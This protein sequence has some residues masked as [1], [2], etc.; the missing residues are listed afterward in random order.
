MKINSVCGVCVAS[1]AFFATTQAA[2][3]GMDLS[4]SA[5]A[6][7]EGASAE[8]EG[9]LDEPPPPPPAPEPEPEPEPEPVAAPPPPAP[10]PPAEDESS[11]K[12]DHSQV[13]LGV[14][15][16]GYREMLIGAAGGGGTATDTVVAP[17]VGVRMWLNPT[18][19]L[20]LGLG[21][22]ATAA[23]QQDQAGNDFDFPGPAAGIVHAG[24]PIALSEHKH[25]IFQLVPEANV[26]F[27]SN[28]VQGVGGAGDQVFRGLHFD[29]GARAG[30]EVQFGFIDIPQL[31]LQAGV[32]A[33]LTYDAT[34][35]EDDG[36]TGETAQMAFGTGVGDNPWN[37]FT[38]NVAAI[39]YLD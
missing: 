21:I 9:A 8:T 11:G 20:D 36:G 27:A 29:L 28:T 37:I 14:G 17:V 33:A 30:A 22:S 25:F 19:G 16:L 38:A 6:D 7:T 5:S 4:G 26:G 2:A 1:L 34:S 35:Y 10:A 24:V 39:Y 31:S 12:T 15:Y 18:V 23:T 3:Q 32:G 13:S